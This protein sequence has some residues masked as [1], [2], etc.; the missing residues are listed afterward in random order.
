MPCAAHTSYMGWRAY[1]TFQ[2][3]VSLVARHCYLFGGLYGQA[4]WSLGHNNNYRQRKKTYIKLV[5]KKVLVKLVAN[6]YY[7]DLNYYR[8]DKF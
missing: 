4:G 8:K 1:K 3:A 7:I 2:P 6:I 5:K